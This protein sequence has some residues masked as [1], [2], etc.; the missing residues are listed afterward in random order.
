MTNLCTTLRYYV[1]SS[2]FGCFAENVASMASSATTKKFVPA[3]YD[4]F[5]DAIGNTPLIFL[6]GASERTGCKI[7]GKAEFLNPG[8]SVVR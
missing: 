6:R 4:G 8:G 1:L 3:V 5:V 2:L 7:Y